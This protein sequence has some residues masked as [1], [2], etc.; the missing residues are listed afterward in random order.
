V[1]PFEDVGSNLG[2]G[3][4]RGFGPS[5]RRAK[6]LAVG[7]QLTKEPFLALAA[8][9][10]ADGRMTKEESAGLLRAAS[11]FGVVEDDYQAVAAATETAVELG[12]VDLGSIT[13]WAKALTYAFA[14][15]L[16]QID[17]SMNA[18]E[19]ETLQR[20]GEGLGLPDLKLKAAASA[21]FDIS[22]LP[23]GHKPERYDLVA[24][25]ARLREKLPSLAPKD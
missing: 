16:T 17:G 4:D 1:A 13:E 21:A 9:A 19:R 7:T 23:G 22:C 11:T 8:L 5:E 15:W 20:L 14:C 12:D 18:S 2:V 24:L 6:L 3:V 10:W 25:E